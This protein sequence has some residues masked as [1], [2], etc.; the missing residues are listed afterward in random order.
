MGGLLVNK[1]HRWKGRLSCLVAKGAF[2]FSDSSGGNT[3]ED[4][5]GGARPSDRGAG[6][7]I[8]Q[9]IHI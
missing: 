1:K 2:E 8:I 6:I 3:R 9:K 7:Q 5:K 4:Q